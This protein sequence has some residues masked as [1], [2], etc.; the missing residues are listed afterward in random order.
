[1]LLGIWS[2]RGPR[3]WGFAIL[4]SVLL[5][6]LFSAS[7]AWADTNVSLGVGQYAQKYVYEYTSFSA[8]GYNGDYSSSTVDDNYK[9][10]S[11]NPKVATAVYWSESCHEDRYWGISDSN[12]AYLRILGK[13]SGIATITLKRNW[14]TRDCRYQRQSD[15]NYGVEED[16]KSEAK[17]YVF[18]VTV[19][20][21]GAIKTSACD[22]LFKT[23]KY[24]VDSLFKNAAFDYANNGSESDQEEGSEDY[25][26]TG[27]ATYKMPS[28]LA[29]GKF[30][31]GKGYKVLS[32]G[33]KIKFT[34]AGKVVV[35]Y[36][37]GKTVYKITCSKVRSLSSFKKAAKKEIKEHLFHPGTFK[38]KKVSF[39][40]NKKE[41][42]YYARV[43][44][45]AKSIYGSRRTVTTDAFYD[46]GG[47]ACDYCL[48]ESG[49]FDAMGEN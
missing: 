10:S 7:Y 23:K 40:W 32:K 19:G 27:P 11:S 26:Y 37:V 20:K 31:K 5:T 4:L 34:K 47:I 42:R 29:G 30:V 8:S 3:I 39:H 14:T 41:G 48:F 35:K 16:E 45:S 25:R 17:E 15:G 24:S 44:Y 1:M 36:K 13:G 6:V 49:E 9:I 33:K 43:K 12:T 21:N 38:L 2:T 46:D 18:K 22:G 28:V